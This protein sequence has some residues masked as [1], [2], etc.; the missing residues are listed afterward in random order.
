MLLPLMG[1]ILF[2]ILLLPFAFGYAALE[3]QARSLA[4]LIRFYLWS[5]CWP[6]L[7]SAVFEILE[8][9]NI[10]LSRDFGGLLALL[11]SFGGALFDWVWR[12]FLRGHASPRRFIP[13][14]ITSTLMVS[15]FFFH[16]FCYLA[17]MDYNPSFEELSLRGSGRDATVSWS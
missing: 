10:W 9:Q 3:P 15:G 4:S 8:L 1:M 13:A 12:Q 2:G 11:A 17:G 5:A 14:L 6:F 7:V 16:F